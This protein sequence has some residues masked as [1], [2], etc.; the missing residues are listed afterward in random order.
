MKR[1][2]FKHIIVLALAG[3]TFGGCGKGFLDVDA[4]GTSLESNYYSNASEAMAALIAAYDPLGMEAAGTYANKLG[5]L[6]CASDDCYAGGGSNS[7]MN[8]WQAWNNYSL[9]PA[10]GPQAE[11]WTRNFTGVSR[12]NILLSKIAGVPGLSDALK[13]RYIAE[14]KFLRAYYYFDLLRL[15]KNVPLFIEP[16]KTEEIYSVKQVDPSKVYEQIEK[17]LKDAITGLPNTVPAA[18]EG[19]R[20]TAGAAK[21]LLGKVIIYQNN[22]A[23][24]LE[25]A[26]YLEDVNKVGNVYGYSLQTKFGDIFSPD[27]K[28]NSESIFEIT[29]TSVSNS[30]WGG[31]PNFEGNVFTQM[32]GPRGY[33]GPTYQAGWGFNVITLDLVNV[34]KNDP[35]YPYTIANIDSLQTAGVS[36]YQPSYQNTGYFIQK[37]APLTKWRSTGGGN[38]ELNYPNDVIEIRLADTY[39]LEAEALVRGNGDLTKA[40]GYLNAVRGRVGLTG[41]T[42]TLDNIYKERRLELATEGHRWFDLVR[43]GQAA[44]VLASKGFKAN[45]HEA[46]P[47][48]LAELTNTQ[49]VQNPGYTQ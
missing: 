17:D 24:M 21:A 46:L 13:T 6:N 1:F 7:D 16:L 14:G 26:N 8:T 27:N 28:Y 32:I 35:R 45:K 44:T 49:L 2:S 11:Y 18:T 39:L 38:A 25:A 5:P 37:F 10:I 41:L 34:M 42:A 22:T 31:W 29:H 30:S 9:D 23:R 40:A 3:Y 33:T 20:A 47:I 48:P 15:F 12:A 4:K 43:T 36:S 19:G